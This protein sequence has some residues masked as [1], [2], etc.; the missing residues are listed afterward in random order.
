MAAISR[1]IQ[2]VAGASEG[3]IRDPRTQPIR[4]MI[5]DDDPDIRAVL[6]V[7]MEM[8]GFDVVAEVGDGDEAVPEAMRTQPDV[9]ILDYMMPKLD[10]SE[11]ADFIRT[12]A[13]HARILAFSGVIHELPE[14]A[15]LFIEKGRLAEMANL[16]AKK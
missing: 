5:V 15:D 12:V 16:I 9:V 8:E 1:A 2:A 4:V 14:W 11:A 3:E 6:R 7:L 13:P 10:G